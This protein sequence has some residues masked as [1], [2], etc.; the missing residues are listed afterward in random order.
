M[1]KIKM[2]EVDLVLPVPLHKK[3]L[4][5]RGF[6]QSALL[7]RH[8]AKRISIPLITDCLVRVKDTVPQVGLHAKER[9][10]NIKNAFEVR[11]KCIEAKRL[12]LID[13]VF[14]TGATVRECSKVLKK[15][16]AKD[17]YVVTLAHG[18]GDF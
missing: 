16:G 2:P 12:M 18:K 4:R 10:K 8:V 5:H 13:D 3:R 15:A 1:L 14:T 11:N 7:A 6:N 17:I 9:K